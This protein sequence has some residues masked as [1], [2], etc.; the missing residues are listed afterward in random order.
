MRRLVPAMLASLAALLV[1]GCATR[2]ESVPPSTPAPPQQADTAWVEPAPAEGNGLVFEVRRFSVTANG[3]RAEV[4]IRNASSVGWSLGREGAAARTF[5]VMLF[6]TGDLDELDR[7]NRDGELPG[8]RRARTIEPALPA[9]LEPGGS[10]AGTIAAPGALAAGRWVRVVLG[11]LTAI[12]DPPEDLRPQVVWI[13]D[14]AYRL[15]G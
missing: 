9:V 4:A 13:T 10:W 8:L 1:A 12:G 2:G 5:G 7:R 6:A 14:H 11:S 3:W 15:R